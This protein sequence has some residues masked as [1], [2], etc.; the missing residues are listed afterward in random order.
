MLLVQRLF[1]V[2]LGVVVLDV[3]VDEGGL[4]EALDGHGDFP[5]VFGEGSGGVGSEGLVSGGHEKGPPAFAGAHQ[6]FAGDAFG[7][8]P[9]GAPRMRWRDG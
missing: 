6:P 2:P 3:I 7:A 5:E 8:G 4:M 9:S 1:P